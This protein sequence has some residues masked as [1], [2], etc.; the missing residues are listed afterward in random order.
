MSAGENLNEG[1]TSKIFLH[2]DGIMTEYV[3]RQEC[4]RVCTGL[5][6]LK[7]RTSSGPKFGVPENAGD[8]QT[9][10]GTVSF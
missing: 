4:R 3:F 1:N 5:I 2:L 6:W 8:I 10:L 9:S 7:I